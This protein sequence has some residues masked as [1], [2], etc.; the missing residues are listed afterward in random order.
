MLVRFF[1]AILGLT[2]LFWQISVTKTDTVALVEVTKF[3]A[4]ADAAEQSASN[5]ALTLFRYN[6]PGQYTSYAVDKTG[7]I[8]GRL[9]LPGSA[10]AKADGT[11]ITLGGKEGYITAPDN[12]AYYIWYPQLGSQIYVFNE[13]GNFLWE[14]EESHYLHVLPR[15]RYILAAAGDQSRMVFVNPDFKVQADF[16]GVLFNRYIMDDNPDLSGAQICLG[17]LDGEVIVAH[18]DRKIYFRQKLGYALKSL[19]CDLQTGDMAAIVERTADKQNMQKDYLLRLKFSLSA[20]KDDKPIETMHAVPAKLETAAEIE[21]PVR[22]VTPSPLV[23]AANTLCFIQVS[24]LDAD[25]LALY[26][27]RKRNSGL[28]ARQLATHAIADGTAVFDSSPDTW[29]SHTV[30]LG[31]EEACL[32]AHRSGRFIVANQRGLLLDRSDLKTERLLNANG[33]SFVQ[34]ERGVFT[35]R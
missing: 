34:S 25:A 31:S 7:L 3:S 33:V 8:T 21:L 9:D 12:G 18:L 35:V 10:V 27:L 28:E 2:W 13:R 4:F 23:I 14:K 24:A 15:G 26:T 17:S 11:Q 19:A 20:P 5:A 1:A 29:K 6:A 30:S 22:T 32:F 16:Q